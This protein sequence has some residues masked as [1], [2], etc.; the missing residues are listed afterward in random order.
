MIFTYKYV[1]IALLPS[2]PNTSPFPALS[3]KYKHMHAHS[4]YTSGAAA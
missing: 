2:L 4:H 1:H 3:Y